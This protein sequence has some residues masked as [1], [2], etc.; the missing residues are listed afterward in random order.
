MKF[1]KLLSILFAFVVLVSLLSVCASAM[2][3]RSLLTDTEKEVYDSLK[4]QI[5]KVASGEVN[6]SVFTAEFPGFQSVWTWEELGAD[7]IEDAAYKLYDKMFEYADTTDIITAL[8]ADLPY[9]FY[10]GGQSVDYE[11][12]GV[13]GSE[14][15]G[16][17]FPDSYDPYA[18]TD[19][20]VITLQ[21]SFAVSSDYGAETTVTRT[22]DIGETVKS[23][24][25]AYADKSDYEKLLGYAKEICDLVEYNEDAANDPSTPY[26]DP[27][28]L[29]SVFDGDEET[30]VVCEG[31]SKAFKYLCDLTSFRSSKIVCY[32]VTGTLNG[33]T[34]A[35]LHMWNVVTMEDGQNYL[36]DI[37]NC[38]SHGAPDHMLLRGGDPISPGVYQFEEMIFSYNDATMALWPSE[39]VLTL[40]ATDYE[41]KPIVLGDLNGDGS[42]NQKDLAMLSKYMRNSSLYPLDG[43]A[44][45]AADIN[46]D[47]NVNQKDLAKLSKYM[48]N[49]TAYPLL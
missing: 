29:I 39:E 19:T 28:Q 40:A 21:L 31:Y 3:A 32:L 33:G 30:K 49:Q 20:V 11:M 10:W 6:S 26:G 18:P 43:Y 2:D 34:G 45:L 25:A 12:N 36:V 17:V 4:A 23:I 5:E 37:T 44:L 7:N 1:H 48:R 24:V 41:P 8:R 35:G 38:D 42:I 9:D 14:D 27:W 46:G 15:L 16:I 47:G 13:S 22:A